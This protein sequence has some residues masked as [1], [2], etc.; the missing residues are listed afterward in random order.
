MRRH[1]SYIIFYLYYLS[2]IYYF[3]IILY[4][5]SLISGHICT[6]WLLQWRISCAP[7]VWNK[8]RKR[9]VYTYSPRS[10]V[11]RRQPCTARGV[12][13]ERFLAQNLRLDLADV[14]AVVTDD[15][16]QAGLPQFPQLKHSEADRGQI[17]FVPE[18]VSKAQAAEIGRYDAP[19]GRAHIG[20]SYSI[21]LSWSELFV[22]LEDATYEQI[23]VLDAV[24][25]S[26]QGQPCAR[27]KEF[28][29]GKS[30]NWSEAEFVQEGAVRG[31][32]VLSTSLDIQGQEVPP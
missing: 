15:A 29:V 8:K 16:R 13:D 23:D 4:S 32:T 21:D 11:D 22:L 25:D 9:P 30:A 7:A 19:E 20:T 27:G 2:I 1:W 17:V 6:N 18:T 24:V 5:S 10:Q 28:Q 12:V 14:V 26:P 31:Q 3:F